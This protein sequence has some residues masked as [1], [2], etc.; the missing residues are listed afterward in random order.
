MRIDYLIFLFSLLPNQPNLTYFGSYKV[1]NSRQGT[2]FKCL[3]SSAAHTFLENCVFKK[4]A[5]VLD[6]FVVFL[7]C[8]S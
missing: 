7:N 6:L 4:V 8:L 5:S 2:R 1:T 3:A